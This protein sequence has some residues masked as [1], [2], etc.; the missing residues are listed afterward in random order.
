MRTRHL[1]AAIISAI[2]LLGLSSCQEGSPSD[3][4]PLLA[5]ADEAYMTAA[6]DDFDAE[7]KVTQ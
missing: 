2:A 5:E 1:I 3:L 4:P 7:I 6:V